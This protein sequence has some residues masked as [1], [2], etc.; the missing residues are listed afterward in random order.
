MWLSIHFITFL[1][2]STSPC[3]FDPEGKFEGIFWQ[4]SK[5]LSHQ[6]LL[7][8]FLSFISI[9]LCVTKTHL[10]TQNDLGH[11]TED[12]S[13]GAGDLAVFRGNRVVLYGWLNVTVV[14]FT[15]HFLLLFEIT[16][17]VCGL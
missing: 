3:Y 9:L 7:Q 17:E 2:P 14:I 8:S 11:L 6:S 15:H 4:K 10:L 16:S 1:W 5:S 13:T 12:Q